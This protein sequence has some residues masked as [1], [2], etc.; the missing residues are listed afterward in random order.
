MD[1]GA[2]Q[3]D[4]PYPF[5]PGPEVRVDVLED[6]VIPT[7]LEMTGPARESLRQ[8]TREWAWDAF[9]YVLMVPT[10]PLATLMK[11]I[12]FYSSPSPSLAA[13]AS[14][15]P[16][17]RLLPTKIGADLRVGPPP[18]RTIGVGTR[19]GRVERARARRARGQTP[20]AC[21]VAK[22]RTVVDAIGVR[23]DRGAGLVCVSLWIDL[24]PRVQSFSDARDGISLAIRPPI[25][26]GHPHAS[27][28]RHETQ[29]RHVR[30]VVHIPGR[31]RAG[32]HDLRVE[33]RER[34]V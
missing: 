26:R 27:R 23:T 30:R 20:A 5:G 32:H 3:P 17:G 34:G 31:L 33:V 9:N 18:T 29:R 2:K 15:S 19:A 14:V 4:L 24:T 28:R 10:Y 12:L 21:A 1:E 13:T 22:A 8:A 6:V 25:T 11:H 7:F 16:R